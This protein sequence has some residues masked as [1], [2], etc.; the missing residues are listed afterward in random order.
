MPALGL[1]SLVLEGECKDGVGGLQGRLAGG[2][3]GLEGIV[4]GIESLGGWEVCY[5][6]LS[7]VLDLN[8]ITSSLQK[9]HTVLERHDGYKC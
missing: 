1:A 5:I 4:D 2:L 3:V 8:W 6:V 9:R 7:F